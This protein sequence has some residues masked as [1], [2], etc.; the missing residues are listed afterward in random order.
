M[1]REAVLRHPASAVPTIW[2]LAWHDVMLPRGSLAEDGGITL[3]GL[4]LNRDL[5]ARED[6]GRLFTTA[7]KWRHR[8][9]GGRQWVIWGLRCC[10]CPVEFSGA[11]FQTLKAG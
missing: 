7:S 5:V 8:R 6:L 4:F 11:V 3:P 9:A 2:P 1:A 10:F